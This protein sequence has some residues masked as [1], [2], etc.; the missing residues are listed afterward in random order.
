MPP[1]TVE[2][3]D[4]VA[5]LARLSL[6][7]EEREAFA[8]QLEQVLAYAEALQALDTTGV[9]PLSHAAA[10]DPFPEDVPRPR[11]PREDAPAPAPA[12]AGGFFNAPRA[13]RGRAPPLDRDRG[14]T[15]GR[16]GCDR[17]RQDEHG[18]VRDGLVGREQRVQGH[19]QPVGPRA[20]AR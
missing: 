11:L 17:G 13:L 2:T 12:A 20:R 8:R 18:R 6:T 10:G 1:V 4:H 3:V 9:E 7:A 15:A 19:A 16:G 14:G 5:R